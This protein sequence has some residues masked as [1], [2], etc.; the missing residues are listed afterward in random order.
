[1]RLAIAIDAG[2]ANDLSGM[3][4]QAYAP[5]LFLSYLV[6]RVEAVYAQ[7][8]AP[9]LDGHPVSTQVHIAAHHEAG[10]LLLGGL[11]RR[12]GAYDPPVPHHR[13]AI[14]KLH[15]FLKLVRHNDDRAALVSQPA[16]DGEELVLLMYGQDCCRFVEDQQPGVAIE[17]LE[18]FNS[19]LHPNRQVLHLRMG[20]DG[21]MVLVAQAAQPA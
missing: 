2:N 21:Q 15:D 18:D 12:H 3:H 5:D 9:T 17:Q 16:K 7:H 4:I 14:R 11:S 10:Q 13:H 1:M 6:A 20:I 8:R 19:L